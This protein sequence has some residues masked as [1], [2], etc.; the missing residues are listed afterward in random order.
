MENWRIVSY[1]EVRKVVPM[2][3]LDGLMVNR[4]LDKRLSFKCNATSTR[5]GR[6]RGVYLGDLGL[7]QG[8]KHRDTCYQHT[9]FT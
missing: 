3:E 4:G 7:F 2:P 6:A 5:R 1:Q 8:H 9:K